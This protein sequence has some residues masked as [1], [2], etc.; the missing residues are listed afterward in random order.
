M[1]DEASKSIYCDAA[2]DGYLCV[3]DDE[4]FIYKAPPDKRIQVLE[5]FA[6]LE[7]LKRLNNGDSATIYTD[8]KH[9][10][11][12]INGCKIRKRSTDFR[13]LRDECRRIIEDRK[14]DVSVQWISRDN[15]KAGKILG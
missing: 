12:Q 3:Y 9:V 14:L 15:N 4:P 2:G 11:D 5:Y 6:V 13:I 8:A 10:A 1:S 7:G